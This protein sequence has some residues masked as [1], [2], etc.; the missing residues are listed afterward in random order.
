MRGL[1]NKTFSSWRFPAATAYYVNWEEG[2][3]DLL[4]PTLP[5]KSMKIF[6]SPPSQPIL[7]TSSHHLTR[8]TTFLKLCPDS[9]SCAELISSSPSILVRLLFPR[10]HSLAACCVATHTHTHP[11]MLRLCNQEPLPRPMQV[12]APWG[13]RPSECFLLQPSD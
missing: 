6:Y 2:E 13:L 10:W 7:A 5:N 12:A 11:R 9:N 8:R 4:P 1:E 3:T